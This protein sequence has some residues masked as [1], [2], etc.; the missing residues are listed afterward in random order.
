[1]VEGATLNATGL[2][3]SLTVNNLQESLDFFRA[4]GFQVEDRWE[5]D[6]VLMGAMLKAGHARLGLS[7]DDGKKGHARVKGV[8][9]RLYLEVSD[10]VDNVA[11]RAKAAGIRVI[12]PN[13][14]TR[15][16]QPR[17]R[18]RRAKRVCAATG[19]RGSTRRSRRWKPHAAAG[20][21]VRQRP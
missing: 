2:M 8:G 21:E 18:G 13:R 11:S 3:P 5:H 14:T 10:D 1:M 6:G 12:R 20:G 16:G 17:V 15:T 4:L 9:M 19:T 7:Q